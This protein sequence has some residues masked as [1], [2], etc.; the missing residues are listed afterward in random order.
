M[1][2]EVRR[3]FEQNLLVA[4]EFSNYFPPNVNPQP[5]KTIIYNEIDRLIS[6]LEGKF[7]LDNEIKKLSTF[8]IYIDEGTPESLSFVGKLRNAKGKV[9]GVDSIISAIDQVLVDYSSLMKLHL[10]E[11]DIMRFRK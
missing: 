9:S 5:Y 2:G 8:S 1:Q 11:I 10:D 6:Y 4:S 7:K 3:K